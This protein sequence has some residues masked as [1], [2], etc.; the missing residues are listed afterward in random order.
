MHVTKEE[1]LEFIRRNQINTGG[2]LNKHE[3]S[4]DRK[5]DGDD[6]FVLKIP[7]WSNNNYVIDGV[8]SFLNAV[9]KE[10]H[11]IPQSMYVRYDYIEVHIFVSVCDPD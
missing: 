11:F 9:R 5:D 10:S 1:V 7:F 4:I 6:Y 8:L 2:A 3:I